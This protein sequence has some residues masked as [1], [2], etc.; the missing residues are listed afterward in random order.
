MTID[1]SDLLCR[2]QREDLR[3]PTLIVKL[4]IKWGELMDIQLPYSKQFG[5][6]QME[7]LYWTKPI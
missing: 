5:E 4:V 2:Y 6:I 1:A 7:I 3:H